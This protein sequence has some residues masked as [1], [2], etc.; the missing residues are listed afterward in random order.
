MTHNIRVISD[1]EGFDIEMYFHNTY[2]LFVCG[3]ILDS[4]LVTAMKGKFLELKSN[5]LKNF[6]MPK[7]RESNGLFWVI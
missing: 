2:D 4:T 6:Y 7:R 3:D 1:L 5:N